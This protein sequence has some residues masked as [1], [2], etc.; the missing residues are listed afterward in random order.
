IEAVAYHQ[1]ECFQAALLFARTEGFLPAPETSHAIKAAI[2]EAQKAEKD[3]VIVFNY[4]G[5]G[6]LDLSAYDSYFRGQLQD[7]AYPREKIEEALRQLP[8]VE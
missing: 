5:H 4:S 1:T 2:D 3:K 7:Y 6:L 8:A